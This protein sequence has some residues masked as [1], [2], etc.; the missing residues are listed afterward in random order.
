MW[1]N[2][3]QMEKVFFRTPQNCK[4]QLSKQNLRGKLQPLDTYSAV[5]L[6]RARALMQ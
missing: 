1:G 6:G 2:A 5:S 4:A 3:T